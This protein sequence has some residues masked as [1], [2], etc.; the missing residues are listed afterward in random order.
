MAS[1]YSIIQY[2][3]NPIA[4]ERINIG[5]VA[6]NDQL[7]K[8]R[9]VSSWKRVRCF[10]TNDSD[11]DYLQE[12]QDK[13]QKLASL[14]LLFSDNVD[15]SQNLNHLHAIARSWGNSVQFT[16]P[17]GSLEDPETLLEDIFE[18][19]LI[20]PPASKAP[21]FRDRQAAAKVAQ[22][23]VRTALANLGKEAEEYFKKNYELK[24]QLGNN[25]FDVAVA[26][27]KPFL[28][29]QGISFEVQTTEQVISSTSWILSDVKKLQPNTPLGVIMLPPKEESWYFEQVKKIYEDSKKRFHCL[30]AEIIEEDDL[31][32]WTNDRLGQEFIAL[33]S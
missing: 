29:V 2:V 30:G 26:N 4:D 10:A 22:N 19:L 21:I 18:D 7:V 6:F 32:S 33:I 3:P 14:G 12:F 15:K 16:E 27:G 8:T 11:I 25:K 5:I 13:I 1:R 28:A 31:E 23:I 20:E 17:K 9:F 24:G